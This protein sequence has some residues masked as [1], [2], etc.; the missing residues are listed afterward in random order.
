MASAHQKLDNLKGI[1]SQ[2]EIAIIAFSGG[3]DSTFLLKVASDVLGDKVLAVTATSAS[4]PQ[5]EL[6]ET[7]LLAKQ[8][9]VRHRIVHT[10]EVEN[11]EYA[12]NPTNRCYHCKTELYSTLDSISQEFKDAVVLNG[13]NLDDVSDYR[14]G[15][16]A[17]TEW[18]VQSP[19]RESGLTKADIRLLSKELGLQ[20]HDK[21]ASPCLSSRIPYGSEVNPEK[22]KQI[23]LGEDFLR[24]LG[25]RELRLRHH[26]DVARIEVAP[27]DFNVVLENSER[28]S[29]ELKKLGFKFVSLDL[30]GFRSGALNEVLAI[31][32]VH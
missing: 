28:I 21:P 3:V 29:S 6:E 11:P 24:S 15:A 17:A 20:T 23:E 32:G 12:K 9:G 4:M 27:N 7:K 13:I 16:K 1:L 26:G 10:K 19:L 2:L 8:I 14:P 25:I 18:K 5:K 31:K 30:K 22:L